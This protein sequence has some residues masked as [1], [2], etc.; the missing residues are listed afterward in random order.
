MDGHD[1][2]RGGYAF[3]RL[4]V[5]GTGGVAFLKEKGSRQQYRSDS[6]SPT[7]P[8]G[9]TTTLFSTE[10]SEK[11][12][13]GWTIGAR[14][15]YAVDAGWSLK[16]EYL[17]AFFGAETFDFQNARA[18]VTRDYTVQEI[19]GYTTIVN[20][21]NPQ[22]VIQIPIYANVVKPG[23]FRT[24]NGRSAKNTVD[25]HLIKIGLNYRF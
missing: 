19:T 15:E 8:S 18:G 16:T 7:V 3:E 11:Q 12:R 10:A 20:P 14:G 21:R 1:P 24:I 25:L 9:V 13:T 2:G 22:Q 5:Y 6:A 17:Y 4:L 23:T